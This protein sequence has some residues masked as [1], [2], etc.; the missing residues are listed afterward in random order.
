MSKHSA[1]GEA[2]KKQRARVLDRDGW[3]CAYC[4]VDLAGSN[5]TVDHVSPIALADGREYD[6]DEL[7]AACRTCNG[8]KQDKVLVRTTWENPRWFG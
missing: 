1:Q 4:S 5:A 7:V 8:R 3:V 2:W 6:D